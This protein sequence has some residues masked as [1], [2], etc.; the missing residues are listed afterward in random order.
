MSQ[1][2]CMLFAK[3]LESRKHRTDPIDVVVQFL[4]NTTISYAIIGGQAAS[5][6]IKSLNLPP[7]SDLHYALSTIDYDILVN[8]ND[9]DRF[10]EDLQTEL[11]MKSVIPLE[12]RQFHDNI[13]SI[14]Y[15][16]NK[17]FQSI[18]DVH[19]CEHDQMPKVT[20]D[21]SKLKYANRKWIYEELKTS[22]N[23][24]SS[25]MESTKTQKRIARCGFL[26]ETCHSA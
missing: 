23:Q 25:T 8:V 12:L 13:I 4:Q 18:I 7:S 2:D 1:T 6:Y 22:I 17:L 26:K 19:I 14:G 10:L 9:R 3:W 24:Y 11:R 5:F 15:Y 21:T 20:E 16:K